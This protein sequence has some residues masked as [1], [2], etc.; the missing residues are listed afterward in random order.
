MLKPKQLSVGDKVGIIVPASPVKEPY[1]TEG[2]ERVRDLGYEPV[3][4]E[5][6]LAG[7]DFLAKKPGDSFADIRRFFEDE[8]ISA[9]WAA[10]GGYGSNL[11]YPFLGDFALPG[12]PKMVIGSSDISYLLWYLLDR[13]NMVVFYGPMAYS[14][15]PDGRFDAENFRRV[16]SGDYD[17]LEIAGRVLVPGRAKGT[18]TGGCLSNF[19]SLIGTPYLPRTARRVLLLEDVGERPYRLD[20]MFWQLAEAGIFSDIKGLILG[21]FPGCFKDEKEKEHF[22]QRIRFYLKD[23]NVPVIYDLPFGHSQNIHTLPLGIEVVIDTARFEGLL[24][25]EKGVLP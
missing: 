16:V 21:E 6:I 1:R 23:L 25:T 18:V 11:L 24:I 4:A 15:L 17:V 20:R 2:L 3:E 7:Y 14:S 8:T 13:L 19:V 10:R 12:A 9:I 5:H 22:L